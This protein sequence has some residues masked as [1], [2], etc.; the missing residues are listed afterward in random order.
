[1]EVH[2]HPDLHHKK[3]NFKEYFFEF[4]MI[5]LA[6]TLGFIAEN[7]RENIGDRTKEK[8]FMTSIIKDLKSDTATYGNYAENNAEI[9]SIIDSLIPLMKSTQRDAHLNEVYFLA[10]MLTLKLLIH[11]P[12]KSTYEQMKN[13]GQL[14]LIGNRQVA[15]SIG[16]YYNSLEIMVSFND[17]LL[18][19]DYDYMRLVGK[20]FDAE[21]LLNILKERKEPSLKPVKLLTED[22]VVINELLASAQYIYGSLQLAQ[23]ITQQRQRSAEN[24]ITLIT[25]KYHIK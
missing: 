18:E 23:N 24:L 4:L 2:H 25:L 8:E 1:M 10:R 7:I 14:R 12:D 15:D 19:H 6:V 20:V 9:Y 11:F 3:K 17:V 22:P 5:F 21:I 13:S 16:S